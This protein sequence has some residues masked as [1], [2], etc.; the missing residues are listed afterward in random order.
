MRLA[1]GVDSFVDSV[2]LREVDV[3]DVRYPQPMCAHGFAPRLDRVFTLLVKVQLRGGRA[4]RPVLEIPLVQGV[5]GASRP[6][7]ETH[8]LKSA[9]PHSF[10][11]APSESETGAW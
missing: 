1:F 11:K 7:A 10:S 3:R 4:V 8:N 9:E 6:L 2:V 5:K